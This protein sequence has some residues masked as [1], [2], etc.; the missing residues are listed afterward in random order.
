MHAAT[1][2]LVP[3]RRP[4]TTGCAAGGALEDV[5]TGAARDVCVCGGGGSPQARSPPLRLLAAP[6]SGGEAAAPATP[7]AAFNADPH[8]HGMLDS[9]QDDRHHDGASW[10]RAGPGLPRTPS[11]PSTD[12]SSITATAS[13]GGGWLAG[14]KSALHKLKR[15]VKAL[16]YAVQ[17]R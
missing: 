4:A 3:G 5:E 7:A 15:E 10:S 1:P 11:Y 16:N 6:P 14:L 8:W 2:S 12:P 9:P 13:T 17:V